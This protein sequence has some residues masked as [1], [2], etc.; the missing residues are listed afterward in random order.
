M[1]DQTNHKVSGT[2]ATALTR[3]AHQCCSPCLAEPR[4]RARPSGPTSLFCDCCDAMMPGSLAKRVAGHPGGQGH[5]DREDDDG[6]A[7]AI[8]VGQGEAVA[9]IPHQVADA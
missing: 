6:P 1:T 8:D 7:A 3:W 2:R 4:P 9:C 5:D